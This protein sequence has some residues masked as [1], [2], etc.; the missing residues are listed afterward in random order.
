MSTKID[1]TTITFTRGDT[2]SIQVGI[3]N[4]DCTP[5]EPEEGDVVRFAMKHN[6]LTGTAYREFTDEQPIVEKNIPIDT[7][8]LELQPEDTKDLG[9]G[10]YFYDIELTHA[11]GK[12]DTFISDGILKLGKEAD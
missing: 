12:V 8:L 3:Y 11:D 10:I 1:G 5:Y 4:Q 7:L 6:T 9:F 2:M